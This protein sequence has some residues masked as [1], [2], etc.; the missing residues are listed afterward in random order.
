MP[1][2]D[3]I[4]AQDMGLI[5]LDSSNA[6][7]TLVLLADSDTQLSTLAD[8]VAYGD[9]SGCAVQD[10]IAIC[11]LASNGAGTDFS[12][13]DYDYNDYL[14]PTPEE[15]MEMTPTPEAVG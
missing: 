11:P 9:L 7:S 14:A 8:F 15:I 2:F 1:G 5:L 6:R 12:Y 13:P 4:E 3:K 10:N